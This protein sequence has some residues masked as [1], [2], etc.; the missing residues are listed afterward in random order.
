MMRTSDLISLSFHNLLRH[1]VRSILTSLGVIFGVGSVIAMLAISEGAKQKALEQLEALGIDKIL[2][3]SRK[4]LD[5]GSSSTST[6]M[7][8]IYGLKESD[9]VNINKMDN[10]VGVT[11]ITD[12]RLS[13]MEGIN[14]LDSKLVGVDSS[15]LVESNSN[16]VKGR[17]FNSFDLKEKIPVCVIGRDAKRKL[18]SLGSKEVIGKEV[19]VSGFSFKIIGELENDIGANFPELGD[20]NNMIFVPRELLKGMLNGYSAIIGRSNNSITM[21]EYDLLM[22]K[23]ADTFYMDDTS[24][25]IAAYMNMSHAGVSDWGIIVPLDLLKQQTSTQNIFTIVMGSIAGISL[26]VG[27]I[28]IMNIMLA[29]VFERR[30]EIGTR[31]ALGAQ[32]GDI[33]FQFLIETVFLTS[34]GGV[35]GI[36]TGVGISQVIT[37]YADMPT[38]YKTWS[39]VASLAIAGSVGVIFGTYPAWKAAQQ[40]PIEVLRAE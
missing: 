19:S 23:V 10:V 38:V 3:Y 17:W 27:G 37:I 4:P 32:K 33:L 7:V 26:I 35:L 6:S 29:S 39:I 31:R 22:A 36:L 30:K 5:S 16:I 13:I 9:L 14:A 11:A 34:L 40:N 28:G 12:S 18:F 8:N 24:K 1:K 15:F 20:P 21:V 25:R 2:L